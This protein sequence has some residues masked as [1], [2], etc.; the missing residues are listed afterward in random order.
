[1]CALESR[2]LQLVA[3]TPAERQRLSDGNDQEVKTFQHPYV[4]SQPDGVTCI[5]AHTHMKSSRHKFQ[6]G[7][8]YYVCRCLA[9]KMTAP[10]R[11][12]KDFCLTSYQHPL[13]YPL[14]AVWSTL[15]PSF[16]S[17]QRNQ[18]WTCQAQWSWEQK[19]ILRL[20]ALWIPTFNQMISTCQEVKSSTVEQTKMV[21]DTAW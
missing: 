21:T 1:M 5:F 13:L 9:A 12:S 19:K 3:Q 4:Y 20:T 10:L 18:N 17:P 8:L 11:G 7:I 16:S 2:Y 14:S 6:I 15:L